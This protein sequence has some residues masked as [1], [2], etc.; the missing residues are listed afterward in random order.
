VKGKFTPMTEHHAIKAQW[1]LDLGFRRTELIGQSRFTHEGRDVSGHFTCFRPDE[2][3]QLPPAT[4]Y[5]ETCA[6]FTNWPDK[7]LQ[8]G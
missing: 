4:E 2:D 8:V 7:L 6:C 5:I 3:E 1:W